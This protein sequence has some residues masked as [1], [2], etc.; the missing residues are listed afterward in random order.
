MAKVAERIILA[1][2]ASCMELEATQFV[3][4]TGRGCHDAMAI[5]YEFLEYNKG[6]DMAMLSMDL[7][8]R[9]DNM[10]VN[11]L[12]DFLVARGCPGDLCC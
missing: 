11:L 7:E 2:L 10:D 4:S 3:S 6:M 5:V 1:R 9:F 12:S 8:G